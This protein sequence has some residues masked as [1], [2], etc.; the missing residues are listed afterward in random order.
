MFVLKKSHNHLSK[1]TIV[2]YLLRIWRGVILEKICGLFI[3]K[4]ET[5]RNKCV[6]IQRG[7]TAFHSATVKIEIH[8]KKYTQKYTTKGNTADFVAINHVFITMCL[9]LNKS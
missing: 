3:R 8:N 7:S 6:S 4:D 9:L 5:V 1:S 2:H